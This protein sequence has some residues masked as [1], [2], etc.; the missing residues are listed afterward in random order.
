[1][2]LCIRLQLPCHIIYIIHVLCQYV[3]VHFPPSLSQHAYNEVNVHK[4]FEQKQNYIYIAHGKKQIPAQT[5]TYSLLTYI[6]IH[7]RRSEDVNLVK[8]VLS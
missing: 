2:Y 3:M 8:H 7:V 6:W 5:L 4:Y 1:M